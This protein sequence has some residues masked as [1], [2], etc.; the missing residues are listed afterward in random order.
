[1]LHLY[2]ELSILL[3]KQKDLANYRMRITA[4]T[5]LYNAGNAVYIIHIC[6]SGRPFA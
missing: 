4:C 1:M 6:I 2:T 5:V 3:N